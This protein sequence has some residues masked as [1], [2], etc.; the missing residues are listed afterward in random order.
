V[1]EAE[2]RRLFVCVDP[3]PAAAADL[4]AL[5]DGLEVARANVPGRS[6][7]LAGRD[8]WH[9]T[10]AF[11]GDVKVGRIDQAGEALDAAAL[12]YGGAPPTIRFA[13]G[14][15]FG[16]GGFTILWAGIGG[17]VADLRRL[18]SAV[19]GELRRHRLPFD[20]KGFRPHLTIARPGTRV[21][22][23]LLSRDVERLERY[24]GPE[25]TVEDMHLVA[26]KLGPHPVYTTLHATALPT[27]PSRRATPP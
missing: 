24:V 20:A 2:A 10:L 1:N 5:V 16:R 12:A 14:G 13:G 6:T 23:A 7:R 11:L 27:R 21:E 3:S 18:A 26:S 4:G 8:R 25:W 22:A 17:D 15:T 19:R 9:I